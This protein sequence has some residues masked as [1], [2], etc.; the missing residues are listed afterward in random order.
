MVSN[1]MCAFQDHE[2]GMFKFVYGTYKN[3]YKAEK[4][5]LRQFLSHWFSSTFYLL[6]LKY[7]F[8]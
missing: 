5:F 7:I 6:T 2:M 4:N 8:K 1:W 3:K